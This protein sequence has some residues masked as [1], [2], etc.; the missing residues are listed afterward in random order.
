[1]KSNNCIKSARKERGLGP[2]IQRAAL[3][4]KRYVLNNGGEE[5]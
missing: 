3:Y 1:M 4:A 5:L 2:R